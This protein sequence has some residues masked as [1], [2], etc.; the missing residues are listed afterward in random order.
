MENNVLVSINCLVYNHESYI[1]Q[2][3]DG[4]VMQKTNFKFEVL[5]HDDASTDKS[6]EIIKEYENKYPDII[7]PIYQSKNQYS[8]NVRV[9]YVYQYPR[10][11]GKYIAICEGDDYWCDEN[12]LQK[13]FDFLEKHP[14][15]YVCCHYNNVID[16][17]GNI[18]ITPENVIERDITI[19]DLSPYLGF[20]HTTSYFFRN[21]WLDKSDEN[22]ELLKPFEVV[23]YDKT[24]AI[25]FLKKGKVRLLG[26]IMSAYRY[27]QH[28][29]TS[30]QARMFS[31]NLTKTII[32]AELAHYNQLKAYGMDIDIKAHW[33]R[34]VTDYSFRKLIKKPT[35]EN[36]D[37]YK[38]GWEKCPYNKTQYIVYLFKYNVLIPKKVKRVIKRILNKIKRIIKHA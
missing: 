11:T 20:P 15:Y 27:I 10:A 6:A 38:E 16:D 8:Q 32:E 3:L 12:K 14:D 26:E 37:L 18:V 7:K 24:F 35:R 33:F 25:Y 30:F 1:R 4:F 28:K 22:K 29:G 36:I 17:D 23:S 21:P 2:C 34:N 31:Q 19:S 9:S 5:V 13:Q